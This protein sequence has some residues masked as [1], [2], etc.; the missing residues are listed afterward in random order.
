MNVRWNCLN[1]AYTFHFQIANLTLCDFLGADHI[2]LTNSVT[3]N[4]DQSPQ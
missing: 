2:S 4:N 3:Y 1:I